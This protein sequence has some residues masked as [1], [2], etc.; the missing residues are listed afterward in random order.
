MPDPIILDLADASNVANT[1]FT[2]LTAGT[3]FTLPTVNF[4]STAF[5]APSQVNNPL[6][7]EISNI[8]TE[9]LT[10][11]ELDGTGVFDKLMRANKAHLMQ[12]FEKG[13]ITGEQYAKT[14]IEMTT[15]VMN[16][17]LQF[18][19]Q[20]EQNYWSNLLL[21]SQARQ[22]EIQAVTANT[23]LEI[24]KAELVT[25]QYDAK[26]SEATYA[27]TKMKLSTE[28]AQ[29]SNITAQIRNS[30][31]QVE[32]LMPLQ[33]LSLVIDN[34]TKSYQLNEIL[35]EE[36]R[37]LVYN[38]DN[39][40]VT[41]YNKANFE[42]TELLPLQKLGLN[43]DNDTKTYQLSDILPEEKRQLTYN[44]DNLMVSEYNKSNYQF[45]EL[46]PLQKAGFVID[47]NTKTY[48][49]NDILPEQKRQLVYTTDNVMVA[50]YNK[51]NF[52]FTEIMPKQRDVLNVDIATKTFQK[53]ELLP[54]Q[55]LL[56]LEQVEVQHSQ[57]SDFKIDGVTPVT[58]S[59][60]KQKELY[61]QQITSYKRDSEYKNA[62][63]YLDA[64]IT[65]KTLDDSLNAPAQ[66]T[67][68]NIDTVL[69][70]L[71]SNNGL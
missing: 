41:E 1:N 45:T 53:D 48:Q 65:Q 14:Y 66:L 35:P 40:M 22:A 15:G 63:M 27:L 49:L 33:K 26:T 13:R 61:T 7:G 43:I 17:S 59:V 11:L 37:K 31:Y 19:L 32:E 29:F 54:T 36:K 50:D 46:M 25:K 28:N 68:I 52:E 30:L 23:Q 42:F 70:N 51:T 56:L 4:S 24:S 64:W 47:N 21:Q 57:T 18:V 5:Q 10:T 62:K 3:N 12:E 58:G 8:T 71:R 34:D 2:A 20:R 6:Y 9:D 38:I 55:K 67:N 44:I 69:S 60:G 39:L 16:M